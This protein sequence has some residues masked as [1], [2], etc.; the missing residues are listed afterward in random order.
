M[1]DA[2]FLAAV[3]AIPWFGA[4]GKTIEVDPPFAVQ[5]VASWT[6]AEAACL[7]QAW[8]DAT[9]EARNELTAF[10]QRHESPGLFRLWRRSFKDWNKVTVETRQRCTAPLIERVWLPFVPEHGLSEN[11]VHGLQWKVMA[12]TAIWMGDQLSS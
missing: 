3:D 7:E 11:L 2:R 12:S 4:C 8:E 9:L 10:L 1:L 6:D 5:P